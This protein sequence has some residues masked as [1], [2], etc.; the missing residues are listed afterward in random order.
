MAEQ[1]YST[2]SKVWDLY[3]RI[4][5]EVRETIANGPY[6]MPGSEP[7]IDNIVIKKDGVKLRGVK[8]YSGLIYR[9]HPGDDWIRVS[10]IT[11]NKTPETKTPVEDHEKLLNILEGYYGP[12]TEKANNK[13]F[14][15]IKIGD[16]EILETFYDGTING[17]TEDIIATLIL[18]ID[19]F[20]F[21]PTQEDVERSKSGGHDKSL[22]NRAKD[23]L[24]S[25]PKK[26]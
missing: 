3:K 10:F 6:S 22:Q 8:G 12:A 21:F 19:Q 15:D 25:L 23:Y 5:S 24:L 26:K 14:Y 16:R 2:D 18:E 20:S 9:W 7:L 1:T 4:D 17:K 13:L 11:E